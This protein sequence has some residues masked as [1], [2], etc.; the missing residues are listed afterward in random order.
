VCGVQFV[1]I[2]FFADVGFT[3]GKL[4]PTTYNCRSLDCA[5]IVHNC[6]MTLCTFPFILFEGVGLHELTRYD[7]GRSDT[8]SRR[9]G[10][11]GP[12]AKVL[13]ILVQLAYVVYDA[14]TQDPPGPGT[15][16]LIVVTCLA[17]VVLICQECRTVYKYEVRKH[18]TGTESLH[19]ETNLSLSLSLSLSLCVC[20]CAR[21][22]AVTVEKKRTNAQFIVHQQ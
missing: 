18:V 3:V 5:K 13:E 4:F 9:G 16:A 20:V 10:A 14:A 1:F 7:H 19:P 21:A 6:C 2:N 8:N 11:D 22:R 15:T 17:E 12:K